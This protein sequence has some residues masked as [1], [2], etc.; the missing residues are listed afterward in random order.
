MAE[1]AKLKEIEDSSGTDN[2]EYRQLVTKLKGMVCDAKEQTVCCE[3]ST[4]S[5]MRKCSS[6]GNKYFLLPSKDK[7]SMIIL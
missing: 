4:V 1:R 7:F 6:E 5:V 3:D 2:E